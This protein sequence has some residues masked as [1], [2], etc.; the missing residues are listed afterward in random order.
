MLVFG[1]Y[2]SNTYVNDLFALNLAT[3]TWQS[4]VPGNR[5]PGRTLGLLRY[6][7]TRNRLLLFGGYG[8]EATGPGYTQINVLN[9]SWALPLT[10]TFAWKKLSPAGFA[11]PARDR[12]NGVYDRFA[13]RLLVTCGGGSGS[14]DTWSL[15]FSDTPTATTIQP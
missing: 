14:N 5:P 12:A 13:D 8:V 15:G 9:D 3:D 10:G 7:S 6:D 2:A 1:G 11:P 4:L